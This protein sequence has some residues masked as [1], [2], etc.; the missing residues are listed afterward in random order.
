M[1]FSVPFIGTLPV[2][3]LLAKNCRALVTSIMCF[4]LPNTKFSFLKVDSVYAYVTCCL[5]HNMFLSHRRDARVL[6]GIKLI[7]VIWHLSTEWESLVTV[8][9]CLKNVIKDEWHNGSFTVP[10]KM[11]AVLW[12]TLY[13]SGCNL[14]PIFLTNW[15]IQYEMRRFLLNPIWVAVRSQAWV[16]N[17]SHAGIMGPNPAR[18]MDV[19]LL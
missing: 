13:E 18:S 10:G 14:C 7:E 16:C 2:L 19:C 15:F 4:I 6:L 12:R 9:L 3:S 11:I 8:L 1:R 5:L 17:C